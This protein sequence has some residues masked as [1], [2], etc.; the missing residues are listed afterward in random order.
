MPA[1]NVDEIDPSVYQPFGLQVPVEE[2]FLSYCPGQ[3][4]WYSVQKSRAKDVD[5]FDY[6]L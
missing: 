4:I 3:K 2:I 5:E 6:W 1:K